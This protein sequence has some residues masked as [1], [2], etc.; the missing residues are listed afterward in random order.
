MSL[1]HIVYPLAGGAIV[2]A[3]AA[4]YLRLFGKVAGISGMVAGSLTRKPNLL[5]LAFVAGLLAGGATLAAYVPHRIA[6]AT[7]LPLGYAIA[8]GLLVGLGT[9]LGSGCT[10]GHGIC[11]VGRLS[12]RSVTAT[13]VFMI[14]GMA[15]A[16]LFYVFG[17]RG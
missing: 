16:T 4:A 3:A 10:S 7:N 13:I 6:P 17:G 2:G 15:T 9:R 1:E 12:P 5:H 11:G 8:A 14:T